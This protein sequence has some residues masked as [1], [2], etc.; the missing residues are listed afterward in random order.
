MGRSSGADQEIVCSRAIGYTGK[1]ILNGGPDFRPNESV[2]FMVVTGS[3]DEKDRYWNAIIDNGGV[4][5]ACGRCKD[6]WGFF[7]ADYAE[8]VAGSDD[9]F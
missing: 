8:A 2:R 6:H 3:Q 5:S 9:E 1:F 4:E 7:M